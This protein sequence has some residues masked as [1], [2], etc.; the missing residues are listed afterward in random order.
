M[1]SAYF[2]S[3]LSSPD[4]LNDDDDALPS[5]QCLKPQWLINKCWQ[6]NIQF[7][8]VK[9]VHTLIADEPCHHDERGFETITRGEVVVVLIPRISAFGLEILTYIYFSYIFLENQ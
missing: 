2:F 6:S 4:H 3:F 8:Q 1:H 9:F 5:N 7:K